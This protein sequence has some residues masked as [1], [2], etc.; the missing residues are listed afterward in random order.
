MLYGKLRG[1]SRDLI[2]GGANSYPAPGE[3]AETGNSTGVTDGNLTSGASQFALTAIL[4]NDRHLFF[5]GKPWKS[6]LSGDFCVFSRRSSATG[7]I[8]SA[9]DFHPISGASTVES[10]GK[11]VFVNGVTLFVHLQTIEITASRLFLL[12][13][14]DI[15]ENR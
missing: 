2:G 12:I 6:Q 5:G 1:G 11:A 13:F 9:V 15:V 3:S 10:F 14:L 8:I 4:G 7:I